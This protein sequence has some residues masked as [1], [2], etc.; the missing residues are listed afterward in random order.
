[1]LSYLVLIQSHL[2]AYWRSSIRY[3]L[4]SQSRLTLA[5]FLLEACPLTLT[6]VRENYIHHGYCLSTKS[7][8]WNILPNFQFWFCLKS[9][10]K[11]YNQS[12]NCIWM[13]LSVLIQYYGSTNSVAAPSTVVRYLQTWSYGYSRISLLHINQHI[14]ITVLHDIS[15]R[16]FI[17]YMQ[18]CCF[19]G[20]VI[21]FLSSVFAFDECYSN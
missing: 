18:Y 5:R 9:L 6:K 20:I 17:R 10:A 3:S 14:Q 16:D 7:N 12:I 4:C 15:T 19:S 8:V 11:K 1:M 13:L 21:Y 2:P